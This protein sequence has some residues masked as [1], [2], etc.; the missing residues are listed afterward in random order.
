MS[1]AGAAGPIPRTF[2]FLFTDLNNPTSNRIYQEIGYRPVCD[3][4]V[5]S[6]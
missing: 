4:H 1:M 3:L 2:C 6:L 5:Y